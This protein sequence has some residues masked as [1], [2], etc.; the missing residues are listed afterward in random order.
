M[1]Q[2]SFFPVNIHHLDGF[3]W[4]VS[5]AQTTADAEIY[6]EHLFAPEA[7]RNFTSDERVLAGGGFLEQV[8][9][10]FLYHG[11]HSRLFPHHL[12]QRINPYT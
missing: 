6:V 9:N 1:E 2:G 7:F 3:G 10:D 5:G 12:H 4:A 8:Q 11:R